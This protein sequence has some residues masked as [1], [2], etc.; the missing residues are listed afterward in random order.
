[1]KSQAKKQAAFLAALAT[2]MPV[3]HAAGAAG[4]GVRTAY[5]WREGN[6]AFAADW[7]AA[8]K[9]SVSVLERE[10]ARRALE[11][12]KKPVYRGGELVGHV[13]E[14]SDAMLMFLLKR[15]GE[16]AATGGSIEDQ[17]KGARETLFQKFAIAFGKKGAGTAS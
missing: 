17:V 6:K 10:A 9:S 15:H 1:M 13:T 2:G 8:L 5:R 12:I 3:K 4:V 14:Y 16:K 11:G 7:E